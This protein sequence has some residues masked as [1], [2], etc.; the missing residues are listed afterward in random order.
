M[1][2]WILKNISEQTFG[3]R[4]GKLFIFVACL[5][6]L[7]CYGYWFF[8]DALGANPIEAI[9]RRAGDWALRFL[10]ITLAISPLRKL[11]G[12]HGLA[13]YRRMLGL[14]TFFYVC[15]HLS[16]YIT[17]DKFFDLAEIIE[18]VI[19]RLFITVGFISFVLLIPLAVTST[20]RMV[21]IL[22]HRWTQLHRL[23][24]VVAMLAVLH[25]WW[26]VKIDTREPAIYAGILAVL[27]GFR[28]TF[29][30]KRRVLPTN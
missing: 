8:T 11:T 7:V 21:D 6:P 9:T 5:I 23:V 2:V 17:L 15:V 14:F 25:F 28:L 26:M 16:L 4:L 20:N 10:L 3:M 19:D 27:L 18:D 24:Y 13:R 29:Y 22:Q 30:L 12:W 1:Q